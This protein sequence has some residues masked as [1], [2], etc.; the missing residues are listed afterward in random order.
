M[1]GLLLTVA[2]LVSAVAFAQPPT[3]WERWYWQTDVEE[4][5]TLQQ[6]P[7]GG[8]II[9]G[10]VLFSPID[11]SVAFLRKTDSQGVEQWQRRYSFDTHTECFA[12]IVTSDSG[13]LLTGDQFYNHQATYVAKLNAEGDTTWKRDIE[14]GD[15]WFDLQ[16]AIAELDSG[17]MVGGRGGFTGPPQQSGA[18]WV[19]LDRN[20]SVI[21]R[22]F[23]G[24][25]YTAG[26]EHTV[27]NDAVSLD[28]GDCIL[29][30]W[31][32]RWSPDTVDL[33][34]EGLTIRINSAGDTVWT[35]RYAAANDSLAFDA[36]CRTSDG[37]F[38]AGGYYGVS[39]WLSLAK[40]NG[41]GDA[42][43][44]RNLPPFTDWTAFLD[45]AGTS[46]GGCAAVAQLPGLNEQAYLL[47][48]SA[49]GDT[50]WHQRWGRSDT[51][52]GGIGVQVRP[53]G[54]YAMLAHVE[55]YSLPYTDVSYLTL[56]AADTGDDV[57]NSRSTPVSDFQLRPN[58]PNPFNPATEIMFDLPRT[59]HVTLK[60]FD[61]LGREVATLT[62]GT[63]QAGEHRTTF[64]ASKLPSG[65]YIYRLQSGMETQ[66]RKMVLL[67]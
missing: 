26:L 1:R 20:G 23:Y 9:A 52:W 54:E 55:L 17:Y 25:R 12:A 65:I 53:N 33:P 22:G 36:I 45:L 64:D 51:T 47:R 42:L 56:L 32:Q 66:S 41:Q 10:T 57:S 14:G 4:A 48:V 15:L 24:G 7:D 35:H 11:S 37:N 50:L 31:C 43:W 58:Y 27:V 6:T 44:T 34:Q 39:R 40:V 16:A 63:M 29:A 13:Y 21:N 8:F 18:S 3:L 59:T 28:G 67:K 5:S 62:N 2:V 61:L 49:S 30:G 60:V 19:M 38:I 46:D